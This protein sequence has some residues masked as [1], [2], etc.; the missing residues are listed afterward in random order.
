MPVFENLKAW[1][2]AHRLVLAT[3]ELT[4]GFPTA[5]R[6]GLSSQARRAAFSVA[7][8]LAEGSAKRGHREFRRFL[9]MAVGSLSEL[10]YTLLVARDLG[11]VTA[12][13]WERVESLRSEV[14]RLTWGLCRAMDRAERSQRAVRLAV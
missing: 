6:Y 5:E 8:N 4:Y 2:A 1:Q 10:R 7:A 9:D 11:I 14:G 13:D 12:A 3:Y